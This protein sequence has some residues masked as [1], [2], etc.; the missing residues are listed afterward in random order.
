MMWWNNKQTQQAHGLTMAD[1]E[2]LAHR[3][4][5]TSPN[6]RK[7]AKRE[8]HAIYEQCL[9]QP[10][11]ASV[12]VP[13]HERMEPAVVVHE[14]VAPDAMSYS[15]QAPE[16]LDAEL[17]DDPV[18]TP[19]VMLDTRAAKVAIKQLH[20]E[21][22][23]KPPV[24]VR[25]IRPEVLPAMAMLPGMGWHV[26]L[27]KGADGKWVL[28]S[29]AGR[30]QVESLPAGAS[31][32]TIENT[33][34]GEKKAS[35]RRL[36]KHILLRRSPVLFYVGFAAII[37]NTL[38]LAGSLY[39][40]QVYDRVIPTQGV[41]T[42]IV[43]TT[44]ALVAAVF[45][46][47]I[48]MAR[49]AIQDRAMKGIDI[50]LGH[51]VFQRLLNIRMDQFPPSVGSLSSQVRGYETIRA[52]VIAAVLYCLIDVP[53]AILFLLV[54]VMLAGLQMA[55]VPIGFFVVSLLVGLMYRK[56]I[57]EHTRNSTMA[58]NKKLGL[59]VETV[60]G[61][62]S[63]KATGAGWHQLN[64]W[65]MLSRESIEEDVSIRHYSEHA[66]YLA[67]FL[68]QSSYVVLVCMGAY[69]AS[70]GLLTT[71]SLIACSI[72]SGRVLA[73]VGALPGLI[74]QWGNSKI[75]LESLEKV[76]A[77]QMDNEGVETPLVPERLLG[78]IMVPALQFAYKEGAQGLKIENLNIGMGEKVGII[79]S[80]G[81][82]KSTLLKLLGGLYKPVQG[83]VLLDGLD[84]QQLSRP[85]LSEHI[86]YVSQEIR[87]L[88]G[89]LR[90]NL[91]IGLVG[92]SDVAILTACEAT[93]L[94]R[95]V[96]GHAKGLDLPIAEGGAGVSGG[97]KQLIALT[98][99]LLA[100][101]SMWLLD[102]PTSAMDE[103][104]EGKALTALQQAA[105]ATQTLLLV[106]HKPALVALVNRLI[107][108][109]PQGILLDGPRD[110]V[111]QRLQGRP[112]SPAPA[113]TVSVNAQKGD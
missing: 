56:R 80:I 6:A 95:L 68:Q 43:L 37:A 15:S 99:L 21:M 49:S 73:P 52:F 79:G 111:L 70:T 39:S 27:G 72:L 74:V 4:A 28:E 107:V 98:R 90:D 30:T 64:R 87:L 40:M 91:T 18:S 35:L 12:A 14:V 17:I 89:S 36:F 55:L 24:W 3:L 53:F 106:T 84:M 25:K 46:L 45:E 57:Q 67:A 9:G 31:Y 94:I 10:K 75:S 105:T 48:K 20:A 93:G 50:E 33:V 77:L 51:S 13:A 97:Q 103:G 81:A 102:E 110:A 7:L 32:S 83:T 61:A 1:F 113:E 76:F 41:P 101:P 26:I 96:S 29:P 66:G 59:L 92:I 65:G 88:Q 16:I 100:K 69:I 60:E 42:L 104:T 108:L 11:P 8:M 86:G 54:I 58:S 44:G 2:W 34:A 109:G 85:W 38:A 47:V 5:V 82:G 22:G 23:L 112:A 78:N 63:I 71:G 62:E 19:P